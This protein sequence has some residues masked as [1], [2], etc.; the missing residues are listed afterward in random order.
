MCKQP[1]LAGEVALGPIREF[2]YDVS[3]LFSDL[4]WPLEGLGLPLE[5]NPGPKFGHNLTID[6]A[7]EHSNI[8]DALSFLSFQREAVLTTRAMLPK[9]KSLILSLIHI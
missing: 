6:N 7:E 1:D 5:F 3:I 8:S 2:D 9:D 4:L